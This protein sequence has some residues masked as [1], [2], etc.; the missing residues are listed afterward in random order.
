MGITI[1]TTQYHT[2][3]AFLLNVRK[4]DERTARYAY[5]R[6]KEGPQDVKEQVDKLAKRLRKA[7]EAA[8]SNISSGKEKQREHHD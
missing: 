7:R 3:L 6:G 8:R 2:L 5:V 4:R 1:T